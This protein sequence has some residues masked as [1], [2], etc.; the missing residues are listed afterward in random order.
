MIDLQKKLYLSLAQTE[1]AA[2]RN[3]YILCDHFKI[4]KTTQTLN[5][6]F[7]ENYSGDY[8]G[9]EL[10]FDAGTDGALI[11]W[12][13]EEMIKYCWDEYGREEC[14]NDQI[15]GGPKCEDNADKDHTAKLYMVF[16]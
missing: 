3:K 14:D 1:L 9:I 6:R 5:D 4:G 10:L 12:M 15:G 8:D 16:R 13:E 11:D 2:K 7:A